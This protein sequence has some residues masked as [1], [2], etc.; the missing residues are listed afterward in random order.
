MKKIIYCVFFALNSCCM[1]S[2]QEKQIIEE[3]NSSVLIEENKKMSF[4]LIGYRNDAPIFRE[5]NSNNLY[6]FD[7]KFSY[8]SEGKSGFVPVFC[9]DSILIYTAIKSSSSCLL[10]NEVIITKGETEKKVFLPNEVSWLISNI[11]G[12][13]LFYT[14]GDNEVD[15]IRIFDVSGNTETLGTTLWY[16]EFW[17][18][19]DM[20]FYSKPNEEN[21]RNEM[22][23]HR[24]IYT[25]ST[26]PVK[27]GTLLSDVI[28]S[29]VHTISSDGNYLVATENFSEHLYCV[30]NLV[31]KEIKRITIEYPRGSTL[32]SFFYRNKVYFHSN[33][34]IITTMQITW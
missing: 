30:I 23:S 26:P 28:V 7:G 34:K 8:Y 11:K 31:T 15:R 18:S 4:L 29:N 2:S 27:D 13:T 16:E 21:W 24:Y 12:D 14:N 17:Y 3:N 5:F 20:F 32:F 33:S 6:C 22:D 25:T 1:F 9:N 10:T 19:K